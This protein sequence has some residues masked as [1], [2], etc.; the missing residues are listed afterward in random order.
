MK[1]F[2]FANFFFF[3]ILRNRLPSLYSDFSIQKDTNPDGYAV[4]VAAWQRALTNAALAGHVVSG[5]GQKKDFLS[6]TTDDNLLRNLEI[7]EWGRPVALTSV[8]VRR[9]SHQL[10]TVIHSADCLS[11][12]TRLSRK[13]AWSL[14][15][16]INQVRS[17]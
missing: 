11:Y 10:D 2:Y 16:F 15:K 12:S 13:E 3:S 8:F 7:P 1:V 14:R 9:R 6:L 5:S 4:N 17:F